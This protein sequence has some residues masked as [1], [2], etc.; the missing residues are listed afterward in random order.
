MML[1]LT[2]ALRVQETFRVSLRARLALGEADLSGADPWGIPVERVE[3]EEEAGQEARPA[4]RQEEG[5][6]PEAAR[7][8]SAAQEP[9]LQAQHPSAPEESGELP[10]ADIPRRPG[11]ETA[12]GRDETATVWEQ[13]SE[14]AASPEARARGFSQMLAAALASMRPKDEMSAEA[15]QGEEESATEEAPGAE[16]GLIDEDV[17]DE[18]PPWM[19]E[20]AVG[21]DAPEAPS[22]ELESLVAEVETGA[23]PEGVEDSTPEVYR[24]LGGLSDDTPVESLVIAEAVTDDLSEPA[25]EPAEE[26]SSWE[27]AGAS[28][29]TEAVEEPEDASLEDSAAQAEVDQP[30][31]IAP[32]AVSPGIEWGSRWQETAQG[33]V[34]EA[35]RTTWRPIVSTSHAL[36]QWDVDTYLGLVSGDA[37][38]SAAA[39]ETGI[40]S[41][42]AAAVQR[43]LDDAVARGA[44]AV[45]GT[46]LSMH[47]LPAGIL[48]TAVGT[49]V[50]L[51]TRD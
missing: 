35:G 7:H 12:H 13:G 25:W 14:P 38:A 3:E 1:I 33:W 43:M 22:D 32:V 36:A 40:A 50:T 41:A 34:D 16:T 9:E 10:G 31:V 24:E 8:P 5:Q 47:A 37:L 48:V 4:D 18:T 29:H 28:P 51:Q 39:A 2:S 19:I 27:D 20:H 17:L 49:A 23:E 21:Q 45:V 30:P 15:D 6:P 44:H 11:T 42:R 46:S 26:P